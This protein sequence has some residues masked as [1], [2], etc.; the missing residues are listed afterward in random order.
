MHVAPGIGHEPD[1]CPVCYPETRCT[2][3]HPDQL[4]AEPLGYTLHEILAPV[5]RLVAGSFSEW[6]DGNSAWMLRHGEDGTDLHQ[7]IIG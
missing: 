5:H 4:I 2:G 3:E 1:R 7:A 6:K